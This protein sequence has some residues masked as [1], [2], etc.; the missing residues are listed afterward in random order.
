MW[1]VTV[2]FFER[3]IELQ[4]AYTACT[5]FTDYTAAITDVSTCIAILLEST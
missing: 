4:T 5:V 3:N 2:P 1:L